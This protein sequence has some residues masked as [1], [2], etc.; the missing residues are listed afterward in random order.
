[1]PSHAA[2]WLRP[3]LPGLAYHSSPFLPVG[4]LLSSPLTHSLPGPLGIPLTPLLSFPLLSSPLLSSLL[5]ERA[6]LD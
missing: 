1:M 2:W 3:G 4:N 5:S 6:S